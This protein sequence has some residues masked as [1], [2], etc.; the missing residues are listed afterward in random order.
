ME[1]ES[2]PEE[3]I[4]VETHHESSESGASVIVN[5]DSDS[6][7]NIESEVD[8]GQVPTRTSETNWWSRECGVKDL[9]KLAIPLVISTVS[10]T[11][12]HFCDRLFL[13]WFSPEAM[14]AVMPAGTFNWTMFCLPMGV[15]GYATTFVAQYVGADQEKKVGAI[16]WQAAGLGMISIPCFAIIAWL[17]PMLFELFGH[18]QSMINLEVS[19]FRILCIGSVAAVFTAALN[20]FYVGRGKTAVVMNTNIIAAII[21]IGL[22]Y[23]F[24]FGGLGLPSMG[25]EGAAIATVIAMWFKVFVYLA[26][27]LRS[28][29]VE[30]YGLREGFKFIPSLFMRLIRFGG[31]S[32][33]QLF[34]EGIAITY[35]TLKIAQVGVM[36]AAATTL[37]F[38]VNMIAFVPI[39]GIGMA[40]MT[41]TGQQLGKS[42]PQNASTATWS[43]MYVAL[44]YSLLF[45][46]TYLT[47]PKF[48]LMAHALSETDPKEG[49]DYVQLESMAIF[50]LRFV[51][52]YCLADAVQI[53]FSS[54]L[55]GAGDTLFLLISSIVMSTIFIGSGYLIQQFVLEHQMFWWWMLITGWIWGL[56]V[57]YCVRYYQGKWRSIT[58]IEPDLVIK[59][60]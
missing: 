43:A 35:F 28:D 54:T 18:S 23:W 9:L 7:S 37:A 24:I 44:A 22:D 45:G 11:V 14:A 57:I 39:I 59:P 33:F 32:G 48:F 29:L 20:S 17:S 58:V 55:K 46:I 30:Q 12:M 8:S 40:V 10:F 56:A 26:L 31:P 13:T 16:V 38:S 60:N 51:A 42:N 25:I 4:L 34:V 2:N 5:H 49:L 15:A 6:E 41:L 47:F 36:E 3:K 27:M 1:I 50:L 21:N 52:A 19:Y 53:I